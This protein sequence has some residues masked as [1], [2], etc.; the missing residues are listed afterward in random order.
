[1]S[2]KLLFIPFW[3]NQEWLFE[4]L[5]PIGKDNGPLTTELAFATLTEV[6]GFC[7]SDLSA[8]LSSPAE[9]GAAICSWGC[10]PT[11]L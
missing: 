9:I 7:R 11:L 10:D 8:V 6:S 4:D 2:L 3:Q 1:M 5:G